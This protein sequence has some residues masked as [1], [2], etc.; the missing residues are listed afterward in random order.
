MTRQLSDERY[1]AK[2][3][4]RGVLAGTDRAKRIAAGMPLFWPDWKAWRRS[5]AASK[6]RAS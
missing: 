4:M 1:A 3:R 2:R 6:R 5:N